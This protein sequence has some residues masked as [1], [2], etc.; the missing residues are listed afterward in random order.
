M[1]TNT[2]TNRFQNDAGKY[3]RYLE[4][5]EGRLRSDLVFSNL[6]EFLEPGK[7]S[8]RVLDLGCGTG[9][10]AV[11]L[12]LLGFQ[13]TLLDSSPAMLEFAQKAA[14]EAG[15]EEKITFK[16]GD[17][18]GLSALFTTEL[19]DVILCHNLFEYVDDPNA[20]LCGARRVMRD[21]SAMLSVLVR[22]QAGEVL[23]AALQ[24]GDLRAAEENLTSNWAQESLYGGKVRLFEPEEMKAM[25]K[26]ATLTP[27]ARRGVRVITDF[28]PARISRSAEYEQIFALERNIGR[29]PEFAAVAR[30]VQ[31]L[32][33]YEA[34]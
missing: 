34:P 20:V 25:L 32:T 18:A 31:Y 21:S 3:A 12:A 14:R 10:I 23:K 13:V 9:A 11:R 2:E 22:N 24:A 28:L 33:R 4:T 1:T 15:I 8:L 19:F 26:K 16:L 29:R 6:L 30:Y 17:A 27:I 5:P 7:D